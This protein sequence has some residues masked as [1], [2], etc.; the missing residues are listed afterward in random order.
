LI[1]WILRQLEKQPSTLFYEAALRD[2]NEADFLELKEKKLLNYV[3]PNSVEE[4]YSPDQSEPKAA[5]NLGGHYTVIDDES[6]ETGLFFLDRTDFNKYS[7]SFETF[8]ILMATANG[9]SKAYK[10]LH[11]RLYYAGE[12]NL[13]DNRVALILAFIDQDR[14]T[15]DLLLG[16]PGRLPAGFKQFCVVTPSYI[17][18]SAELLERLER[19]QT[20]VIPL[21]DFN[22][23]KI[24]LSP[25]IKEGEVVLTPEEEEE[26]RLYGFQY[27]KPIYITGERAGQASN[28]IMVGDTRVSI[29]D[30][31]FALFL[32]LVLELHKQ[33]SGEVPKSYL[34]A[35]GYFKKDEDEY[36]KISRLRQCF[37]NI[38]GIDRLD[39]IKDQNKT[40]K[41]SVHPT[42]ITWDI[43]RLLNHSDL[44]ILKLVKQLPKKP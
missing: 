4:V 5:I 17:T 3:Q 16:L 12:R 28:F 19:Q 18:K 21:K 37:A 10:N 8:A 33:R 40:L 1:E 9:F 22:E 2:K 31:P 42:L 20:F 43:G 39:F 14:R 41:L 29:G 6:P 24:D 27:E 25:L 34:S 13:D 30:S 7:F 36:Q 38:P 11:R 44:D 26:C 35:E 32:R 23:F 15:E